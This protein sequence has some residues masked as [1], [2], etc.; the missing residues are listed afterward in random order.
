MDR[1]HRGDEDVRKRWEP[2]AERSRGVELG[3][4]AGG[5][6]ERGATEDWAGVSG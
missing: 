2:G 6:V 5:A 4:A 3:V 1:C